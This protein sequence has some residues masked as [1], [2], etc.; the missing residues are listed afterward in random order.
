MRLYRNRILHDNT[1]YT[2]SRNADV[3]NINKSRIKY[4]NNL[5]GLMWY[6]LTDR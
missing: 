5:H 6:K 4:N 2:Q 1:H 3:V